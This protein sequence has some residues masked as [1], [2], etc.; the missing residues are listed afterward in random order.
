MD[1]DKINIYKLLLDAKG[2]PFQTCE[3]YQAYLEKT[4]DLVLDFQEF[5]SHIPQ[6]LQGPALIDLESAI[7]MIEKRPLKSLTLRNV[8]KIGYLLMLSEKMLNSKNIKVLRLENSDQM[9]KK[10]IVDATL[11]ATS[12]L[13]MKIIIDKIKIDSTRG[14]LDLQEGLEALIKAGG[15]VQS[16]EWAISKDPSNAQQLF[17]YIKS[18]GI[19]ISDNSQGGGA[20][21]VHDVDNSQG[22]GAGGVHDDNFKLEFFRLVFIIVSISSLLLYFFDDLKVEAAASEK[23]DNHEGMIH[24]AEKELI[25]PTLEEDI[26][27]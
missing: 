18:Q 21:G 24:N 11:D 23:L 4:D 27:G 2:N 14:L 22:G 12:E 26:E 9:A 10:L 5:D 7:S 1:R 25:I 15:T 6:L 8:G 19:T 3:A 17:K 13:K 20:G 16:I